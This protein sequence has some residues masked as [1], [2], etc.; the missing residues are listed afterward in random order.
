ML[1]V[2]VLSELSITHTKTKDAQLSLINIFN[3]DIHSYS[4]TVKTPEGDREHYKKCNEMQR[5]HQSKSIFGDNV[6]SPAASLKNAAA[7]LMHKFR[8]NA[9]KGYFSIFRNTR[10]SLWITLESVIMLNEGTSSSR[11]ASI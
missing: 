7:W 11:R 10:V 2:S 6:T 3:S 9:A 1:S 5:N 8:V 4:D